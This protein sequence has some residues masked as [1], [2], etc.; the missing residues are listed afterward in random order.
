MGLTGLRIKLS[1]S[2]VISTSLT[3]KRIAFGKRTAWEFPDLNTLTQ[4]YNLDIV[5]SIGHFD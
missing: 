2:L 4:Y 1:P 5:I 3:S